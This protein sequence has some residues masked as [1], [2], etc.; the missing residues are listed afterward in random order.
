MDLTDLLIIQ[1]TFKFRANQ[2]E[3]FFIQNQNLKFQYED[4]KKI[5][6]TIGCEN[7]FLFNNTVLNNVYEDRQ[8]YFKIYT[9][10]KSQITFL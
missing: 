4:C 8:K 5:N 7:M 1:Y 10:K 2:E 6:Q 3:S 9:S